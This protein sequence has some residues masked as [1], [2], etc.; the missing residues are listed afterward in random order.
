[1][2]TKLFAVSE[3]Q[4]KE[5]ETPL[6]LGWEENKFVKDETYLSDL[7]DDGLFISADEAIV[8]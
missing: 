4:V 1:M 8:L 3:S 7:W 6:V 5:V 2:L